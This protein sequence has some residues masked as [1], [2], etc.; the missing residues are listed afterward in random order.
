MVSIFLTV[1]AQIMALFS[2]LILFLK[3]DSNA[4]GG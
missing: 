1:T 4:S 3:C 2:G